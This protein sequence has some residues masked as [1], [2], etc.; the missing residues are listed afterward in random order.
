MIFSTLKVKCFYT[1]LY[2]TGHELEGEPWYDGGSE[3]FLQ[4]HPNLHQL[5]IVD[6]VVTNAHGAHGVLVTLKVQAK[7]G[8]VIEDLL[9]DQKSY[10]IVKSR[11]GKN[12]GLLELRRDLSAEEW[13]TECNV[14]KNA[15][16]IK[17]CGFYQESA[18]KQ[19]IDFALATRNKSLFMS[20]T[21]ELKERK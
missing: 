20:L 1:D 19:L 8:L 16:L 12:L 14:K 13:L 18:M 2:P 11:D 4:D 3:L 10:D 7:V 21:N 15:D 6:W 17:I 5:D 9:V